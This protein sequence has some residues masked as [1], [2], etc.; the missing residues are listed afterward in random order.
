MEE[1]RLTI[2]VAIP[3][4]NAEKYIEKCISAV[5]SLNPPADRIL[6]IDDGSS[7]KTVEIA[8]RYKDVEV[9][10]HRCNLGVAAARNT[11][12]NLCK[13]DILLFF[14]SD[15]IPDK[16]FVKRIMDCYDNDYVGGVGGIALEVSNKTLV[17]KWRAL[18]MKQSER[19]T[20]DV[21][22]LW[23]LCSSYK[24]S[25]LREVGGFDP[26]FKTNG[27]DVDIGIRLR[28]K[29]YCLI[30]NP[31]AKVKHLKEENI[32]GVFKTLYNWYYWGA[33]AFKKNKERFFL[34]YIK[35]IF[36]NP[37]TRI[38]S[39][40]EG[41]LHPFFLIMDFLAICVETVALISVLLKRL[42]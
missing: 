12:L 4:Y 32:K 36:K 40:K 9:I 13:E 26:V 39:M 29:G 16:D 30:C 2:L 19:A 18:S 41:G 35:I 31:L 5:I 7:D 17:E 34:N 6:I 24:V 21:P 37:I 10:E 42:R 28:K 15:T 33:Y 25:L 38:F 3:A 27:E 14:D 22:F 11:A 8:R 23:G 1:D 20:S